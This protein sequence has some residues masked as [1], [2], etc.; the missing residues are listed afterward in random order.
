MSTERSLYVPSK[1]CKSKTARGGGGEEMYGWDYCGRVKD[2]GR[3]RCG[4]IGRCRFT[5]VVD[6]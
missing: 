1:V 6:M 3:A 2:G 4:K 5:L